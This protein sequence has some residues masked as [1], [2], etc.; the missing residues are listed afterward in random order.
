MEHWQMVEWRTG[1][2]NGKL[3]GRRGV[4]R[5]V[6]GWIKGERDDWWLENHWKNKGVERW[7][8]RDVSE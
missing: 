3:A 7:G 4:V 6:N 1:P 5:E 8:W 2:K